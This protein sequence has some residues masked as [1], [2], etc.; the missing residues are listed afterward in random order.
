M[1]RLETKSRVPFISVILISALGLAYEVLLM[2]LF[3]IIHWH[4]FAYMIISVALLGYGAS[5]TFVMIAQSWIHK[6]FERLFQ[7]N[8]I[9]FALSSFGCYLLAQL[10]P[11]NALELLWEP[12]QWIWLM[13]L[14]ILL[15][16]P[17]FSVANC[18]AMCLIH[19]KQNINRIYAA[20]LFGAALGGIAII[21]L[22]LVS[23]PESVLKIISSCA[24]LI[25]LISLIEMR[26]RLRSTWILLLLAIIIW[27][28]PNQVTTLN[29]SEFKQLSQ[30]TKVMGANIVDQKSSPLGLLTVVENE[31]IPFRYFPG[32][33]LVTGSEPPP[34]IAVFTDASGLTAINKYS[35]VNQD[36]G[37][38]NQSTSAL[39]YHVFS[40]PPT[41]L[42]LG[43]GGGSDILQAKYFQAVS[44]DAVE[45]NQQ[46]IGLVKN[47]YADFSG[48]V[49]E[50]EHI[51]VHNADVRQY[52]Q[53]TDKKFDIIQASLLE[54]FAAA[55]A[56]LTS[57]HEDYLY[58]VEAVKL[59]YEH[60][61]DNGILTLTRWI[62]IPPRDTLKLVATI[63]QVLRTKNISNPENH[64]AVI[65][66]WNTTTILL[67]KNPFSTIGINRIK[68]FSDNRGFDVVYFPGIK[69]EE[70]NLFNRLNQA[71][72]YEGASAIL[73]NKKNEFLQ[74]YQYNL[75]PAT[76]DRPYFFH[77][78]KFQNIPSI[79][80]LPHTQILP[81]IE[82]GTII[83]FLTLLQACVVSVVFIVLPLLLNRQK[84][85]EKPKRSVSSFV[86]NYFVLIGLAFM[87]IEIAFIQKFILYLG[88]PVYAFTV[89]VCAF[90]FFA[91][92]GSYYSKQYFQNIKPIKIIMP[93][94]F[95][96][97]LHL[98][99][100]TAVFEWLI[101]INQFLKILVSVILIAPLAFFMGMPFPLAMDHLGKTAENYIPWAWAINACASVISA[102]L[103][104]LLAVQLGFTW[105]LLIALVLYVIAGM[106]FTRQQNKKYQAL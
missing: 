59:Y 7:F 65:R 30:T 58:T 41:V 16:I 66:S 39:A 95:F 80:S 75:A 48:N 61:T 28:L 51:N 87:F 63:E 60:L 29:P 37:L 92:I 20:D 104:T 103:A 33:S 98:I 105:V 106:L 4:H 43:M 54:S 101:E 21:I 24:L 19:F 14:Y 102:I 9:L 90:L 18:V 31:I 53:T 40:D 96:A 100:L 70:V 52:I 3:S 89:V 50:E 6:H 32:M 35:G 13:G 68:E 49:L 73:S 8:I 88:H 34:Q 22:L 84:I 81:L 91:S 38:F 55:N 71:Y 25:G 85:I 86:F 5:G 17:F 99:S 1:S 94:V 47:D 97:I 46:M 23:F 76:D 82:W 78:L 79:F 83:L 67:K 93:I 69:K 62:K 64:I 12:T 56:G 36:L 42:I 26:S 72:F 27:G 74:Q 15:A 2:R 10:I 77:F 45:L 11:F 57:L 44:I